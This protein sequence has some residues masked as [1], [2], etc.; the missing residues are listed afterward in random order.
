VTTLVTGVTTVAFVIK[1]N[2]CLYGGYGYHDYLACPMFTFA[3]T[4]TKVTSVGYCGY[5][6]A[7][8]VFRSADIS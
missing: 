2:Q 8:A 3:V 5:P 7:F 1:V 6:K 4:V